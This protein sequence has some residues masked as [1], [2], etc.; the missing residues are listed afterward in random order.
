MGTSL[1]LKDRESVA[2]HQQVNGDLISVVRQRVCGSS[3]AG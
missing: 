2:V 3:S 1:V